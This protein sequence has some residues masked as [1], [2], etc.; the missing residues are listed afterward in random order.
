[1][2]T[3]INYEKMRLKDEV[4]RQRAR[5]GALQCELDAESR[6]KE[7]WMAVSAILLLAHMI[8]F[9]ALLAGDIDVIESLIGAGE[10]V[11]R[12]LWAYN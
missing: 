10:W 4:S 11:M 12:G 5:G 7:N 8:T 9:V 1:M 3:Y 2:A 6:K